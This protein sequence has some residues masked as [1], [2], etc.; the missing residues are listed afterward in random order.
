MVYYGTL[1]CLLLT[2]WSL[3]DAFLPEAT[4]TALVLAA[5]GCVVS[6]TL[7]V[8]M[9][10]EGESFCPLCMIVHVVNLALLPGLRLMSQRSIP[11]LI[12]ALRGAGSYL[13][14]LSFCKV[15]NQSQLS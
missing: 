6:V 5:V 4:L 13:L 14:G 11:Q 9:L 12:D 1:L 2:G 7:T 8:M 3:G 15:L 10:A